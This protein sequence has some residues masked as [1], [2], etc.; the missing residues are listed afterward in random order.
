MIPLNI[1]ENVL[2]KTHLFGRKD[3][4]VWDE[5]LQGEDRNV[6][7]A[8]DDAKVVP[9]DPREAIVHTWDEAG[10][11][12]FETLWKRVKTAVDTQ[13]SEDEWSALM[14]AC[15]SPVDTTTFLEKMITADVD[16]MAQDTDGWTALHWSAFHGR[17]S[18]A[19][20]LLSLLPETVGKVLLEM[21]DKNGKTAQDVAHDE[22]NTEVVSVLTDDAWSVI[23]A[24][25]VLEATS[26]RKRKGED[27]KDITNVD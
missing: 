20:T 22:G 26:M 1:Y 7:A 25:E 6:V 21:K 18:S 16:V 14:I 4:R 12:D 3:K 17:P 13:T 23:D 11:G 2:I 15:G 24:G 8:V 27:A 10:E 9:E 5:K 19:N